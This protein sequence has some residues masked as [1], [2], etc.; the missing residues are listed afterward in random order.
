[1]ISPVKQAWLFKW[2]VKAAATTPVEPWSCRQFISWHHGF[3]RP[4]QNFRVSQDQ[5]SHYVF[6]DYLFYDLGSQE[7]AI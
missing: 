3:N 2:K 7:D 6:P 4:P 1:M 5:Y